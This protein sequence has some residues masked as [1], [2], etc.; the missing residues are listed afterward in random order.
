VAAVKLLDLLG[1]QRLAEPASRPPL[2]P[3]RS[4]SSTWSPPACS[5]TVPGWA[6]A[7]LIAVSPVHMA[8]SRSGEPMA[9]GLLVVAISYLALVGLIQTGERAWLAIYAV[10]LVVALYTDPTTAYA[11]APQLV[12]GLALLRRGDRRAGGRVL[13]AAGLATV[14]AI[15]WVLHLRDAADWPDLNRGRDDY[16]TAIWPRLI[17]ALPLVAGLDG[18]GSWLRADPPAWVPP[19]ALVMLAG[20][21]PAGIAGVAALRG[22]PASTVCTATM[23]GAPILAVLASLLADGFTVIALAPALIGW[24][25]L[26]SA[27]LAR[28]VDVDVRRW[29]AIGWTVLLLSSIATVPASYDAAR[30]EP[31]RDA[32]PTLTSQAH[33]GLPILVENGDALADRTT[34]SR[35]VSDRGAVDGT[36]SWL[37]D[38]AHEQI[39][40]TELGDAL[41]SPDPPVQAFWLIPRGSTHLLDEPIEAL[42]FGLVMGIDLES[43]GASMEGRLELWARP[44]AARRRSRPDRRRLPGAGQPG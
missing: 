30:G 8:L 35:L 22:R 13:A 11:L 25:I 9:A 36:G 3:S 43:Y 23:L 28:G 15:P 33:L 5:G 38:P 26:A 12:V 18:L 32:A 7:A 4:P 20:A 16:L 27:W 39:D 31:W 40:A 29:G 1:I 14:A 34:V 2:A 19:S 21:L 6:A 41:A 10:S 17:D 42:G 24:S 37:D 44:G